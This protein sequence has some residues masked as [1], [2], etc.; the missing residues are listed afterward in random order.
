M[1]VLAQISGFIAWLCLLVSYYRKN[2]DKI[3]VFHILSIVFYLLK[4]GVKS[5]LNS[6]SGF[7]RT[8][9]AMALRAVLSNISTLPKMNFLIAD[10]L[11]GRVSKD[12]LD[13]IRNL[14]EKILVSYDFILQISHLDEIKDW[15]DTIISCKK[16]N[17]ISKIVLEK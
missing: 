4:D 17:N 11:W 12:N 2:T 9:S 3:L 8:A 10:E 1:F 16:E 14:M 6:A 15:H 7:E 5:D 13:N